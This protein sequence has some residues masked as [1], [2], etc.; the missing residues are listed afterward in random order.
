M[1]RRIDKGMKKTIATIAVAVLSFALLAG[2][3]SK[4]VE[5]LAKSPDTTSPATTAPDTSQEDRE[6]VAKAAT[7][8][9]VTL[10][11]E[12]KAFEKTKKKISYA[13]IDEAFPKSFAVYDS[14]TFDTKEHTYFAVYMDG[15]LAA[16]T[17]SESPKTN[18]SDLYTVKDVSKITI[19][20]DKATFKSTAVAGMKTVEPVEDFTFN[21]VNGKW[22]L[23]G[24]KYTDAYFKSL[25]VPASFTL[26]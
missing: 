20:G 13:A 5:P 24:G 11:A 14:S 23:D 1:Y 9:F 21:K 22:L 4:T 25:G 16:F 17:A 12:S 19:T 10:S 3:G 15:S 7:V 18:V 26:K 8:F 6:A 2:C